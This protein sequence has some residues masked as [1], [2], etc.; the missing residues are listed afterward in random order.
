MPF[1]NQKLLP[2][3]LDQDVDR[4]MDHIQR[5]VFAKQDVLTSIFYTVD[6][7]VNSFQIMAARMDLNHTI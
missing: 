4:L 5:L 7:I 6:E 1:H 2:N 3:D